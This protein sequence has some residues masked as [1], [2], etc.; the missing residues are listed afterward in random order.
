MMNKREKLLENLNQLN[1]NEMIIKLD[2]TINSISHNQLSFEEGLNILIDYEIQSKEY[3]RTNRIIESASLPYRK[4]INDFDLDFQ[5]KLPKEELLSLFSNEYIEKKENVVFLGSSGVGKTHLATSLGIHAAMASKS[6]YYIKCNDLIAILKKANLENRLL[7]MLRHYTG[8][9]VLI[10]DELGYLPIDK[11]D[12]K[13]FFQLI[14]RRYEKKSTIITT[15]INFSKWDTIFQDPVIANAILDRILHH[16]NV[17]NIPGKSY[18]LRD[19]Y[20][21][22][23]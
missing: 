1:L 14:D 23:N 17:I 11:E 16:S 4:T 5:E 9:A 6:V 2:D 12:S 10:I 20:I 22:N 15:N 18:R 7:Y 19:Y 8:Y 3:K 13:L 21:D